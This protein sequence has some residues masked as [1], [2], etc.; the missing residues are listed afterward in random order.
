MSDITEAISQEEIADSLENAPIVGQE[1]EATSSEELE[2]TDG[3]PVEQETATEEEEGDDWLPSEQE[4]VFPPEVISRYAK[5]YGWTNEEL[6]ADPRLM[7][8]VHDKINSDI[9]IQELR[10]QPQEEKPELVQQKQEPTQ[11]PLTAQQ[12][13]AQVEEK[14]KAFVDPDVANIFASKFL[15]A[16]GV[17]EAPTPEMAQGLT[18]TMTSF[19]INLMNSVLPQML[20]APMPDGRTFFQT[21][22]EQNYEG[23]NE[24]QESRT[25]ERAWTKARADFPGFAKMGLDEAGPRLQEAA[26]K[27]FGD[28]EEFERA[29]FKGK[30]GKPLS[31][32]QNSVKKYSVL[33][34]AMAGQKVSL[35]EAKTLQEAG[36][37]AALKTQMKRQSQNLGAGQSKGQIAQNFSSNE[38]IFGEGLELYKREHGSI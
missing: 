28:P 27:F 16:F 12:W 14:A 20:Q 2:Q 6:E 5:R 32:Y 8:F 9:Y 4:K 10:N 31:P 11:P 25:Y 15:N 35:A 23:F 21:L 36:K 1:E 17:K 13:M 22:I 29:I 30:D 24:D 34:R 19:G 37:K 33:A 18:H 7:Q 38:D 26:A 3:E